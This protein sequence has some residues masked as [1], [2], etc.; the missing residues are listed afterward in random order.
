M[1]N[2]LQQQNTQSHS[3]PARLAVALQSARA[4]D[5]PL[6]ELEYVLAQAM[7]KAFAD[8]GQK[9]T[10]R[11]DEITYLVQNMPAQ[12]ISNLPA[13]RLNE[14]P[15]AINRGI[16]QHFGPFYGLN[17]ASFMHFLI[18]HC[19]CAQRAQALKSLPQPSPAAPTYPSPAEQQRTR[20]NRIAEAFAKYKSEGFYNDYG[21]LV[22]DS[23]NALGVLS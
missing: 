14:I 2:T 19:R 16:M 9:V 3:M 23:I 10:D 18:A 22:F 21:N 5:A 6:S 7:A 15:I 1:D 20:V 4:I 8:M 11:S 13:I 12:V 17:V